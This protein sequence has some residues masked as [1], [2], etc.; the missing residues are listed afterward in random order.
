MAIAPASLSSSA[1]L[2]QDVRSTQANIANKNNFNSIVEKQ[3]AD[4]S[5]SV[6]SQIQSQ[7]AAKVSQKVDIRV[8][9]EDRV[10]QKQINLS[11]S[12][13]REA[14]LASGHQNQRPGSNL[15]ISV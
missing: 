13:N 3:K 6:A 5:A 2:L 7:S 15:D 4:K 9:D 1:S 12:F 10:E 8:G 14:P 11:Q